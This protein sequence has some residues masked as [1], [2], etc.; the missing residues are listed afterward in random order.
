MQILAKEEELKQVRQK[1]SA[2]VQEFS[3]QSVKLSETES[4]LE[5]AEKQLTQLQVQTTPTHPK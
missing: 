2:L 4:S 5:E 1:E 3:T